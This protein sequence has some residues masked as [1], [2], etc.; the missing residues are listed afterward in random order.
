MEGFCTDNT[1]DQNTIDG[2]DTNTIV[3]SLPY[4]K[5]IIERNKGQNISMTLQTT[6]GIVEKSRFGGADF[7]MKTTTVGF[8]KTYLGDPRSP[9][10]QTFTNPGLNPNPF[11]IFNDTGILRVYTDFS[12]DE[13]VYKD[14]WWTALNGILPNNVTVDSVSV[15]ASANTVTSAT[16]IS[17]I[18]FLLV[19]NDTGVE[20]N[21]SFLDFSLASGYSANS[22]LTVTASNL[23][24]VNSLT[25][26]LTLLT[27]IVTAT[28]GITYY[29]KMVEIKYH[30]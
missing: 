13:G 2:T 18:Q 21:Y 28:S 11:G 25:N 1:F 20:Q 6:N 8:A 5:M 26:N 17:Q 4:N 30:W 27:Q 19:S 15:S 29:V 12:V 22:V 16:D 10:W 3:N 23:N 9:A 14:V 24:A 7:N